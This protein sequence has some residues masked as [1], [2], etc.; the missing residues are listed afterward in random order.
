MAEAL[1]YLNQV[2]VHN[3]LRNL[4]D[5]QFYSLPVDASKNN[6]ELMIKLMRTN[7]TKMKNNNIIVTLENDADRQQD[8]LNELTHERS[9]ID[10][11]ELIRARVARLRQINERTRL[12]Q[13]LHRDYL[14]AADLTIPEDQIQIN[15]IG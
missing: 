10:E 14:R 15:N 12:I 9:A 2:H 7:I 5:I 3:L 1:R 8:E 6:N 4:D 11:G 13:Q